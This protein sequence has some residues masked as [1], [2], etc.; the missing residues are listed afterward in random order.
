M[1]NMSTNS[2]ELNLD[3]FSVFK[4]RVTIDEG[5][6]EFITSLVNHFRVDDVL[7]LDANSDL[8]FLMPA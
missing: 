2:L 1:Q 7:V 8:K 4:D 5:D 6:G 3:L